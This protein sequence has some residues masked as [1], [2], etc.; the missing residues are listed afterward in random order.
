MPQGRPSLAP[1][2][3]PPRWCNRVSR[4]ASQG[5]AGLQ[6]RLTERLLSGRGSSDPWQMDAPV[7]RRR[8]RPIAGA[9]SP[10]VCSD[11]QARR[12]WTTLQRTPVAGCRS[13]V[14]SRGSVAAGLQ[15]R[16]TERLLPGRGVFSPA[17]SGCSRRAPQGSS[18]RR[19][20][21]AG[22]SA[23]TYRHAGDWTT[24]RRTTVAGCRSRVCSRGSSDPPHGTA[25]TRPRVFGP[26][27]SG[28]SR[29]AP[30]GSSNRQRVLAEESAQ[31]YRH[32]GF[33]RPCDARRSLVAT[34]DLPPAPICQGSRN[35]FVIG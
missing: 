33:G 22:G 10:R 21:L 8:A 11:V 13:R 19:R 14:C 35:A 1:A 2:L 4:C 29:R 3:R 32:A 9:S 31:T 26:A 24:L 15:T 34:A 7:A 27:A 5:A 23:Q 18:N 25:S 12:L 20:V 6:T 17:A 28:C 30:Q 16:L